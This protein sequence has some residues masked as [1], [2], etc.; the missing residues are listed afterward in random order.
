LLKDISISDENIL[1][2]LT[3]AASDETERLEKLNV[4]KTQASTSA[5][6]LEC[7][8][9]A[10][11]PKKE[12]SLLKELKEIR[13][14]INELTLVKRDVEDLKS[15]VSN[16]SKFQNNRYNMQTRCSDCSRKNIK[17][18]HCLVCGSSEHFKAGC[19]S[20]IHQKTKKSC[21]ERDRDNFCK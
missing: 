21:L 6:E 3:Q 17:C 5:V 16:N 18:D 2:T 20:D 9:E 19:K 13:L 8:P 4:R 1:D 14:Q 15:H 12:N 7:N 10:S 11:L